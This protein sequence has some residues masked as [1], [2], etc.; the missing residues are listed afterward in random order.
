M[1]C[2][3]PGAA[4][5]D[6]GVLVCAWLVRSIWAR[7]SAATSASTT[8]PASRPGTSSSRCSIER[9]L[10]VYLTN[11]EMHLN[12][13]VVLA[14]RIKL[15]RDNPIMQVQLIKCLG[16]CICPS[17]GIS[18]M[19]DDACCHH[20]MSQGLDH[21]SLYCTFPYAMSLQK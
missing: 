3:A 21:Q 18:N 10:F 2:A 11:L 7:P 9:N 8:A 1:S 20:V 17:I 5:A 15:I 13:W 12:S 4:I 14:N 16:Y 19:N 6:F